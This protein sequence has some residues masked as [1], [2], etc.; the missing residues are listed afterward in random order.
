MKF[1]PLFTFLSVCLVATV[2]VL[3]SAPA[4]AKRL[5]GGGS[6]GKSYNY[7]RPA[8]PA[9]TPARDQLQPGGQQVKPGATR[10]GGLAGPLMGLAAGGLLAAMFFGGAFEGINFFDILL[11]AGLAIGVMLLLRPFRR[12]AGQQASGQYR[13]VPAGGPVTGYQ[14]RESAVNPATASGDAFQVP[15]IGSGLRGESLSV[16][17]SWFNEQAFMAEVKNH[18]SALHRA[19]EARDLDEIRSYSTVEFF[20]HLE[21]QMAREPESIGM[22]EIS[23][24]DAQMLDLLQDGDKVVAAIL[25]RGTEKAEGSL[26]EDFAEIWHVEHPADAAQ[27]D[28]TLAGIRQMD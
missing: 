9:A 12:P 22:T 14:R 17:P 21:Q 6:F 25:F 23:G 24:L 10:K 19:W 27:G 13:E 7:L 20:A 11:I 4:E 8:K 18:F 2:M 15:N 1:K 5:G 16:Q 26:A 3:S 28:W